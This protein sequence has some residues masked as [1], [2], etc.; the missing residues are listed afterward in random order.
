MNLPNL[1]IGS[2]F[3]AILET[4]SAQLG[5]LF[6]CSSSNATKAA[7]FALSL[8][9]QSQ[10]G[11]AGWAGFGPEGEGPKFMSRNVILLFIR[12]IA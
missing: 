1:Q 11:P 9:C 8:P 5:E 2:N 4:I 7:N 10:E 3:R 12:A 6:F